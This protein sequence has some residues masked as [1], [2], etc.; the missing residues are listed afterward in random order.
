MARNAL[1]AA[2]WANDAT[3][4]VRL[5]AL[6]QTD[7]NEKDRR[8]FSPLC[9]A[10]QLG[11]SAIAGRLLSCETVDVLSCDARG[12]TALF[13]AAQY[14]TPQVAEDLLKRGADP[15]AASE[16][17]RT[18]LHQALQ[19][20]DA[21]RMMRTLLQNDYWKERPGVRSY[22]KTRAFQEA[23]EQNY[24]D[25]ARVFLDDG[26]EVNRRLYRSNPAAFPWRGYTQVAPLTLAAERGCERIVRRL[27]A[28]GADVEWNGYCRL[29]SREVDVAHGSHILLHSLIDAGAAT[30]KTADRNNTPIV[31]LACLSNDERL[32]HVVIECGANVN[33]ADDW[34]RTPLS[35]SAGQD[36][37]GLVQFLIQHG[38]DPAAQ[39][40]TGYSRILRAAVGSR[41]GDTVAR[42][43]VETYGL[44]PDNG[45]E[46][47]AAVPGPDLMRFLIAS[48]ADVNAVTTSLK[49]TPLAW[50]CLWR[51]KDAVEILLAAG[52]T[53][54]RH[55][56]RDSNTA[57]SLAA[58]GGSA[59]TTRLLLE[60][61]TVEQW[62]LNR[63][64]ECAANGG[65]VKTVRL[66]LDFGADP[67]AVRFS[68][69]QTYYG[70]DSE[71]KNHEAVA[72][73]FAE[74]GVTVGRRAEA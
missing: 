53:V 34:G 26:E 61:G 21:A 5:L 8:G 18:V 31:T 40:E 30:K 51:R 42:W 52:A 36:N 37:L 60:T 74:Y 25:V 47:L 58:G 27:L 17:V 66:L 28:R 19:N 4:V 7:A 54:S 16:N 38:A 10:I 29:D 20:R 22:Q 32:V 55:E 70:G 35:A 6:P 50:A 41:N 39:G 68:L 45:G 71:R 49:R 67:R 44:G 9:R 13:W 48:G 12:R 23:V 56:T 64:L 3:E 15:A 1:H 57:L 43:L 14:G 65:H 11:R 62:D 33:Q 2:I 73:V 59:R 69:R 46:A 24:A 72:A 63:A